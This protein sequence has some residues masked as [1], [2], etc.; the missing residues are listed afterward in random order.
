VPL[1]LRLS[2][3]GDALRDMISIHAYIAQDNPPAAARTARRLD[4]A[5]MGLCDFPHIGR[6]GR[7][8]G[9]RELVSVR[10]YVIVYRLRP[11]VVEIVRIW[12]A[13]QARSV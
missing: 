5:C 13:A 11:G 10:P 12:H 3:S 7:V 4:N 1:T 6:P 2:I 9:T 8:L